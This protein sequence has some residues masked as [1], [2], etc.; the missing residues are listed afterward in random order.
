MSKF[1]PNQDNVYQ[2]ISGQLAG[3]EFAKPSY[4][5]NTVY[6]GGVGDALQGLADHECPAR[7]YTVSAKLKLVSVSRNYANHFPQRHCV[8]CGKGKYSRVARLR[9]HES[10]ARAFAGNKL[11]LPAPALGFCLPSCIA[12]SRFPETGL[13]IDPNRS[14]LS[15]RLLH[16]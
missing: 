1:S 14:A 15:L 2:L 10:R 8:G 6:Y 12:A 3:Q 5:N 4:L 16:R 11:I 13:P 9:Y 7:R